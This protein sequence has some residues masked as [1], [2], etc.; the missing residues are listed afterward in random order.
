MDRSTRLSTKFGQRSRSV[1]TNLVAAVDNVWKTLSAGGGPEMAWRSG[2]SSGPARHPARRVIRPGA[3][4]SRHPARAILGLLA[5]NDSGGLGDP[6]EPALAG[7]QRSAQLVL[8]TRRFVAARTTGRRAG[9]V[10][11]G[12]VG[13]EPTPVGPGGIAGSG[14]RSRA[15][16]GTGRHRAAIADS[17]AASAT[18][19]RIGSDSGQ[20]PIAN[21]S[22]LG[23]VEV[24][25]DRSSEYRSPRRDHTRSM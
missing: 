22:T 24:E 16:G 14:R 20:P 13:R 7:S 21:I 25:A 6:S 11:V 15:Q 8:H 9:P 3:G 18:H 4:R 5:A 23:R 17:A 12:F 10:G 1:S 19:A 2:A